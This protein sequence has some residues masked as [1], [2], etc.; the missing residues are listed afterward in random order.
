MSK[1]EQRDFGNDVGTR[2]A[3]GRAIVRRWHQ[4]VAH[5]QVL[6]RAY[7]RL[8]RFVSRG[9]SEETEGA[10]SSAAALGGYNANLLTAEG[11]KPAKSM[12]ADPHDRGWLLQWPTALISH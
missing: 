2:P 12:Y 7:I 9:L 5:S 1:A 6:S 10:L 8:W 11:L 3:G 4:W